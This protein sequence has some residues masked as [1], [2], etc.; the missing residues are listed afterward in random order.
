[1][2]TREPSPSLASAL[3]LRERVWNAVH[4][5]NDF[6][7]CDL[8]AALAPAPQDSPVER[9]LRELAA[10]AEEQRMRFAQVD[11]GHQLFDRGRDH[12][13]FDA[14]LDM[15]ERID[16]ILAGTEAPEAELL[17]APT[18]SRTLTEDEEGY[19]E[20]MDRTI[21]GHVKPAEPKGESTHSVC[22]TC[23]GA[24]FVRSS[25]GALP[26]AMSYHMMPCPACRPIDKATIDAIVKKAEPVSEELRKAFDKPAEPKATSGWTS[27]CERQRDA[28]IERA[29][30]A[31]AREPKATS[32]TVAA[33]LRVKES[34]HCPAGEDCGPPWIYMHQQADKELKRA[35]AEAKEAPA[36]SIRVTQQL[37]DEA[38]A[39]EVRCHAE[40]T[41]AGIPD[42]ALDERVKQMHLQL[43][44]ALRERDAARQEAANANAIAG[45]C[46]ATNVNLTEGLAASRAHVER[47]TK[48]LADAKADVESLLAL[49]VNCESM[50]KGRDAAIARAE[51]AE[52]LLG[53]TRA[54]LKT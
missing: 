36:V 35:R 18:V 9:K 42:G 29:E 25:G 12:G 54:L 13:M 48:E 40:L 44:N 17:I 52:H 6:L 22:A 19:V 23:D 21:K 5:S 11:G 43:D 26:G 24:G 31:E 45:A 20:H 30:K 28:A 8:T 37:Y 3:S 39:R 27:E 4:A 47:L 41:R 15:E 38:L 34:G 50:A 53:L 16:A 46:R 10:Y 7:R 32:A 1:M 2:T 14:Y 49:K 51:A 33:L